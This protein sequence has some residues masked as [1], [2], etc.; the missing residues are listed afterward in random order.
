MT[1]QV[2]KRVLFAAKFLFGK[3]GKNWVKGSCLQTVNTNNVCV[4]NAVW[5]AVKKLQY[6]EEVGDIATNYLRVVLKDLGY[7]HLTLMRFNDD[8][9]T[10][11][12]N[13]NE[14]FEVAINRIKPLIGANGESAS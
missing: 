5:L 9:K 2:I 13:V 3:N 1:E 11:F 8:P 7:D 12:E 10:T 6:S 14:L 4:T